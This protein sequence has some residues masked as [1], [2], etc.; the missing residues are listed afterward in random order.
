MIRKTE[1]TFLFVLVTLNLQQQFL[2]AT[3]PLNWSVESDRISSCGIV[4][5]VV[6][7][8]QYVDTESTVRNMVESVTIA[9]QDI[10][11]LMDLDIRIKK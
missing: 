3:N 9:V 5:C 4:L 2:V 7:V 6:F 8:F 11:D 1:F 10:R